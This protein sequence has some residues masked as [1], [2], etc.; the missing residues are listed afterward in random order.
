MIVIFFGLLEQGWTAILS[1]VNRLTK[2]TSTTNDCVGHGGFSY[3]AD[4]A[5]HG[6]YF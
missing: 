2:K 5:F 3:G 6:T 4:T 1:A